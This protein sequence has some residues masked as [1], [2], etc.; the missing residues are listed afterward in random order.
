MPS[1]SPPRWPL[2]LTGAID[3]LSRIVGLVAIWLVPR[4]PK[5]SPEIPVVVQAALAVA[6]RET[7]INCGSWGCY[8][9]YSLLNV[10]DVPVVYAA[11][12]RDAGR[13]A[14][15]MRSQGRRILHLCYD[16]DAESVQQLYPQAGV[17]PVSTGTSVW[18]LFRVNPG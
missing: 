16:C 17:A 13:F 10:D 15:D 3:E 4:P 6:D 12:P 11:T 8:Y 18:K 9:P 2:A 7:V 14:D 5:A 1:S